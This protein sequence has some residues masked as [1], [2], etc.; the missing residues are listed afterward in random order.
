M[1]HEDEKEHCSLQEKSLM[2][3]TEKDTVKQEA[4]IEQ[5]KDDRKPERE[6]GAAVVLQ[7]CSP[8]VTF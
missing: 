4:Q 2:S 1:A 8:Y 5:V 7:S 3:A 6:T